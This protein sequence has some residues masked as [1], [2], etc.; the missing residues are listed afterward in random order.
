MEICTQNQEG[1]DQ[2]LIFDPIPLFVCN[3]KSMLIEKKTNSKI[4]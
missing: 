2:K 4:N 1:L 3:E